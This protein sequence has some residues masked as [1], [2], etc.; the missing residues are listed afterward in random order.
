MMYSD[1]KTS[2]LPYIAVGIIVLL[3]VFGGIGMLFSSQNEV[4]DESAAAVKAAVQRTAVQCYVVEGM[5]PPDLAY[6]EE[7]YGLRINQ[8]DFVVV[9][10]AFSSNLPPSIRVMARNQGR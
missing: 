5:Y 6:L 2:R 9:Y 10:D 7:N 4:K 8:K 3:V 1:K